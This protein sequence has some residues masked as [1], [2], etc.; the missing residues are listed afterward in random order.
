MMTV[1]MKG[2]I[3]MKLKMTTKKE[4]LGD[5]GTCVDIVEERLHQ[6][7]TWFFVKVV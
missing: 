5:D 2:K 4:L 7:H 3:T 1:T 6:D